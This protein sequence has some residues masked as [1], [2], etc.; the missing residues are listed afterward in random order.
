MEGPVD[1]AQLEPTIVSVRLV[2]L[3]TIARMTST[4]AASST[5]VGEARV[6]TVQYSAS[7]CVSAQEV[8]RGRDV[9]RGSTS[10]PQALVSTMA[11]VEKANQESSSVN[12]LVGMR[13]ID[14]RRI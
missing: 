12:A 8:G 6:L 2:W 13:G 3:V 9:R 7:G 14:A 10:V 11:P 4:S 5:P 1:K